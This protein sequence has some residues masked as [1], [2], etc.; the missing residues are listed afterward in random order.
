[1]KNLTKILS[2]GDVLYA[3]KFCALVNLTRCCYAFLGNG[4]LR[5]GSH[6]AQ[7]TSSALSTRRH[8]PCQDHGGQS[9]LGRRENGH[10]YMQVNT[11]CI[12]LKERVHHPYKKSC[13]RLSDCSCPVV[14]RLTKHG[15]GTLSYQR[16]V[17]NIKG[18]LTAV[19]DVSSVSP[20]SEQSG[21][22]WVDRRTMFTSI[23]RHFSKFSCL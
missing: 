11:Y 12:H 4:A 6:S 21:G 18:K 3:I 1:M 13:S 14:Y 17:D 16:E 23:M 2:R 7:R 19:A 20:S 5:M 22:L 10:H 8:N 9:V 15:A